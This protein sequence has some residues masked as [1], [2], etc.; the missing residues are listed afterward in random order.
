VLNLDIKFLKDKYK[1]LVYSDKE[2]FL[3]ELKFVRDSADFTKI[4]AEP[5]LIY[6]VGKK[7]AFYYALCFHFSLLKKKVLDYS[8]IT[9]RQYLDQHFLDRADRDSLYKEALSTELSFIS[10][11]ANDNTND[12]MEQLLIDLVE[13][14]FYKNDVTVIFIDMSEG[15]I[16]VKKLDRY[17]RN[18]SF[19]VLDLTKKAQDEKVTSNGTIATKKGRIL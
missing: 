5:I 18:N 1:S 6:S 9:S 10:L 3:E 14:R 12:Y 15:A 7:R 19:A 4:P 11:S 2:K 17:F 13:N 8:L 16:E